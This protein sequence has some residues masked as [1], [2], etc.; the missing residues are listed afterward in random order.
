[1]DLKKLKDMFPAND[2]EWRVGSSGEKNG[3]VWAMGL[4][5]VTNRAIMDR[6]DD[7]CGPGGWRNEFKSAPDGGILC[8]ISIKVDDE[9][10]T[11]WDGA[12]NTQFEAVKGGLSGAMKRAGVQW[13][14]GRYLYNLDATFVKIDA[15][16]K[17][18][19]KTKKGTW[20]KWHTP[21]LPNWAIPKDDKQVPKQESGSGLNKFK[22]HMHD[23]DAIMKK[24]K[25]DDF[26]KTEIT[27]YY[28]KTKNIP[29]LE[30]V[31]QVANFI[32][33]FDLVH[34]SYLNTK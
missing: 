30:T 14:I 17:N 28:C 10:V 13:G 31:E 15:S 2:I 29:E 19:A 25:M 21:Q 8:G 4:A 5:Y 7:V 18:S 6:L 32:N 27:N 22:R 1:M 26:T 16:G 24:W 23:L 12:E 3:K 34:S 11:K 20:F 33:K 9:W